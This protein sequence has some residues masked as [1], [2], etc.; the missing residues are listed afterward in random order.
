LNGATPDPTPPAREPDDVARLKLAQ[1][2][3]RAQYAIAWE[4]VWPH[5]AR[6]CTLT[7]LFLTLSWAG[8]WL[9]LPQRF[10]LERALIR[11]SAEEQLLDMREGVN[12]VV[13]ATLKD[14]FT[15]K[16][17]TEGIASLLGYRRLDRAQDATLAPAIAENLFLGQTFARDAEVDALIGKL[18][19]EQVNAALRK[20]IK[21]GEFA[22]AYAGDFK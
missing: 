17:L 12:E 4:R 2:L 22:A 14:G 13:A 15:Q 3:Q 16:E 10:I 1:A 21:P 8:L 20:Y 19:L 5:L 9:S 7:G 18:T 6:L 11:P